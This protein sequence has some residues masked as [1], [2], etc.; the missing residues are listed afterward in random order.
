MLLNGHKHEFP[1]GDDV[2]KGYRQLTP[3][4]QSQSPAMAQFLVCGFKLFFD[5]DGVSK[6]NQFYA[7]YGHPFNVVL[8]LL[9][10]DRPIQ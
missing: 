2:I 5:P 9:S 10:N 4:L 1:H 3:V 8:P 7:L 6:D